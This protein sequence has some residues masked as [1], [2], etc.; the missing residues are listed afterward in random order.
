MPSDGPA[1]RQESAVTNVQQGLVRAAGSLKYEA[2]SHCLIGCISAA[3]VLLFMRTSASL[4]TLEHNTVSYDSL[5]VAL[6]L[7]RRYDALFAGLATGLFLA[8]FE[9]AELSKLRFNA[10][11]YTGRPSQAT[12][13]LEL[14]GASG[15]KDRTW[16]L[17]TPC[18][19]TLLV[20]VATV[21][22]AV[23][24]LSVTI[25]GF[26]ALIPSLLCTDLR[27]RVERD[28]RKGL[29]ELDVSY[30]REFGRY[31]RRQR[32]L[33]AGVCVPIVALITWLYVHI[34]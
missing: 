18:V 31:L 12:A 7:G 4:S 5:W 2:L 34:G 21:L 16:L 17:W 11:K 27:I 24:G 15:Q 6:L 26:S 1:G 23:L 25:W 33:F 32:Q 28:V 8:L 13:A 9:R 10:G 22:V 30:E 20:A 19:R 29:R 3:T 14:P